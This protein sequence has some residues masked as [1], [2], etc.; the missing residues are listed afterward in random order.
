M[1]TGLL[2]TIQMKEYKITGKKQLDALS[3]M[4]YVTIFIIAILA[5]YQY[6][7]ELDNELLFYYGIFF[8]I[9]LA[10]VAFLHIEYL[11]RNGNYR[12]IVDVNNN[13]FKI[14]IPK[15]KEES[16][17]SFDDI[18]QIVIYCAPSVKYKRTIKILPFE[19][20]HFARIFT[21][22]GKQYIITSLLMEDISEGL[23]IVP[24]IKV[25]FKIRLFATTLY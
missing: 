8:L 5:Y 17:V 11:R 9:S 2:N 15:E 12:F 21:K 22:I 23:K 13:Y 25:R 1:D 20:Y 6:K 16:I 10:P 24:N 19:H 14:Y 18:E 4:R 3:F 7:G